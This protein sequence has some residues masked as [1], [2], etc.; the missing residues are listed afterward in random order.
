MCEGLTPGLLQ[1]FLADLEGRT[2]VVP[3][4]LTVDGLR[5]VLAGCLVLPH[6]Q[7]G[8]VLASKKKLLLV[9]TARHK[10]VC[11]SLPLVRRAEK[12][13]FSRGTVPGKAAA[14]DPPRRLPHDSD[15]SSGY[16]RGS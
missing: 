9:R 2:L 4:D 7:S 1:V 8:R 16:Q 13:G 3:G 14:N 11:P 15:P 6:V 10:T 5:D 12:R